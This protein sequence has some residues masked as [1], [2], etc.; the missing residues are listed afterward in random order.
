ME[1]TGNFKHTDAELAADPDLGRDHASWGM[2]ARYADRT[3]ARA[4]ASL[5]P[6]SSTFDRDRGP[7]SVFALGLHWKLQSLSHR[8]TVYLKHDAQPMN[9]IIYIGDQVPVDR[10]SNGQVI[11]PSFTGASV[12]RSSMA[13]SKRKP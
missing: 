7:V 12:T 9:F 11:Q 1:R 10:R 6:D 8:K 13:S 2:A 4:E 5:T 3:L